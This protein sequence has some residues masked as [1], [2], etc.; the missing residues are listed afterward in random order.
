ML[1][2]PTFSKY[3]TGIHALDDQTIHA[4]TLPSI[5]IEFQNKK[6]RDPEVIVHTLITF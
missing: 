4:D 3:I 1:D 5:K 2:N 6:Q